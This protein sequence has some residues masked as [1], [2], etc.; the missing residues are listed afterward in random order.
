MQA[1]PVLEVGR[2]QHFIA[3]S[4]T[5]SFHDFYIP[6][7]C[8]YPVSGVLAGRQINGQLRG[9]ASIQIDGVL[10]PSI[11]E[12]SCLRSR[13]VFHDLPVRAQINE[14]KRHQEFGQGAKLMTK[15]GTAAARTV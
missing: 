12:R 1:Y 8:I 7:D 14:R 5:E 9:P 4:M 2:P 10:V 15:R 11:G 3:P 6:I 13:S